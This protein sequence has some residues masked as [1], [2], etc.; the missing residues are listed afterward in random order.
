M[1][2]IIHKFIKNSLNLPRYVKRIMVIFTDFNL[3]F[4]STWFAFYL[5]LEDF[6]LF[7]YAPLNASLFSVLLALPVFWILGVYRVIFRFA[8]SSI[9]FTVFVA[10]FA[11]SLLYFA[12]IGIYEIQGIPRS[13]GII[14]PILLF[15]SI[16]ASR[17]TIKFLFSMNFKKSKNKTNVLIYGAGSAGRQ[18]LT[19]LENNLEMKVVGFLDDNTQFH[20][21]EILGQTVYDPLNIDKLINTKNIVFVLLALPSITRQKRNQ[22]INNLNKFK[23]TVKTLPSI[24][25]IVDGKV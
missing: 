24:Q 15:L 14:Q 5:R 3:C 18:L 22:I 16:L 10:A 19:S 20:K 6:N 23:V 12:V 2:L 9:I 17:I 11:Y 1:Q 8:G 25:D 7:T 13:I 4:L 21:Q